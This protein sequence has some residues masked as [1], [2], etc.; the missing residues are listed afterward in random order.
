VGVALSARASVD[1]LQ[2]DPCAE[3]LRIAELI[4]PRLPE[5]EA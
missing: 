2:I 4:E 1:G 5:P 3:A